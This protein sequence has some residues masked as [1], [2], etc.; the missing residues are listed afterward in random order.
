VAD[1]RVFVLDSFA[2]LA[3]LQGESGMERVQSILRDAEKGRAAVHICTIN[4][5]EVL[6]IIE[7][8][9]GLVRAHETL[10]A[11]QQ[12]PIEVIPADNSTV[13]DAAH[14]KANH[15]VSYADAFAVV[16]A[17]RTGGVL[18]T[19]DKEFESVEEVIHVE[20]LQRA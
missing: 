15:T 5:G 1:K 6:Y 3:Y 18:L 17:Q 16:C 7:R 20:W 13:L 9:Q 8:E 11:I 4:L 2:L 14:I 12:L 10:A 19:G